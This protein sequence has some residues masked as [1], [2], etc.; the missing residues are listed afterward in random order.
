MTPYIYTKT[1]YFHESHR[2]A[3][4]NASDFNSVLSRIM[5]LQC[6]LGEGEDFG[7]ASMLSLG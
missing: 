6:P 4:V 5:S 1:I 3:I 2:T 7:P